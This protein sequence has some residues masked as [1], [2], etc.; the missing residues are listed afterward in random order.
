M[1]ETTPELLARLVNEGGRILLSGGGLSKLPAEY[2]D[3][4]K[5][6]IRDD[7][8]DNGAFKRPIPSNVRAIIWNRNISHEAAGRLNQAVEGLHA[9]KFPMQ[10]TAEIRQLLSCIVPL[11][12]AIMEEEVESEAVPTSIEVHTEETTDM[13]KKPAEKGSVKAFVAKYIDVKKDFSARGSITAEGARLY[14]KAKSEGL[15]TTENSLIQAVGVLLREW[16]GAKEKK[17]FIAPAPAKKKASNDDFSELDE[18][19]AE[20]INKLE[21]SV[22]AI[23]LVQEHLPKVKVETE[24]LRGLRERLMKVLE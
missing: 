11:S 16:K 17:P 13:A 9:L 14:Q 10:R 12:T 20:A 7:N 4:P 19:I 18:L 5:L 2:Q 24:R 15:K 22:A 8:V 21:A 6:I 23:K 1:P 3:H